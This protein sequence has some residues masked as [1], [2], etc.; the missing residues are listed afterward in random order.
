[1]L[2]YAIYQNELAMA[3]CATNEAKA[4]HPVYDTTVVIDMDH[5][6]SACTDG[7]SRL[8]NWL[9]V[10]PFSWCLFLVRG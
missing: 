1:M 2:E 10:L 6:R 7:L 9:I 4:G 5:G 3:T 8:C